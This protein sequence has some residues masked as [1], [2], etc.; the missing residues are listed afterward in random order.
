V[1]LDKVRGAVVDPSIE[2]FLR[3]AGAPAGPVQSPLFARNLARTFLDAQSKRHDADY[4]LNKS[5]SEADARV[6][7]TRVAHVI[8]DW[9]SADSQA[10]QDFKTALCMLMLLKGQ[11][12]REN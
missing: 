5:L 7:G 6:L 9:R 8:A 3:S 2:E 1:A 4:D 11:L 10:D 12:R